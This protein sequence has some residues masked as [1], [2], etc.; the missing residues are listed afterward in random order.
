M[1]RQLGTVEEGIRTPGTH[2]ASWNLGSLDSGIY[3]VKLR[4]RGTALTRRVVVIR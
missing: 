1:G 4:T 2:E 3:F